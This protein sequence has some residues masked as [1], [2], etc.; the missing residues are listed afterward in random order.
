MAWIHEVRRDI[1]EL[2]FKFE[3]NGFA[4]AQIGAKFSDTACLR[5]CIA[6]VIEK[7]RLWRWRPDLFPKQ[8]WVFL[9]DIEDDDRPT[10]RQRKK[11]AFADRDEVLRAAMR[12]HLL[13][14]DNKVI[15]IIQPLAEIECLGVLAGH[16]FGLISKNWN[17]VQYIC[18]KMSRTSKYRVPYLGEMSSWIWMRFECNGK[19]ISTCGHI[20]HGEG[21]GQATGS[22]L[23][24]L[25]KTS[26][27]LRADWYM[28][29]HD[30]RLEATKADIIYPKEHPGSRELRCKTVPKIN[31]GSFSRAYMIS[32][33]KPEYPEERMMRP[34]T[35]GTGSLKG[36]VRTATRRED[37]SQ[38]LVIRWK[39]EI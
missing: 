24:K 21:G 14:L 38:N 39:C 9:G 18:H 25:E 27:G 23:K 37:N 15:P 29:A 34:L 26:I 10:T 6:E 17:T 28:R 4:D 19:N 13:Y 36:T 3:I 8:Y 16:H 20:Q 30:C 1:P 22:A 12:D 7:D 35:M 5:E 33:G 2:P 31:L 11:A 32:K